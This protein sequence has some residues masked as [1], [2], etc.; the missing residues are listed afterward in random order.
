MPRT[1]T[2]E[3]ETTETPEVQ[4]AL[5]GV[6]EDATPETVDV[7]VLAIDLPT[8]ARADRSLVQ[9][10]LRVGLLN[11][12][13][14]I[15]RGNRF[16]VLA[17]RRRVNAVKAIVSD[18]ALTDDQRVRFAK[19]EARV[20]ER[21]D[22]NT[23]ERAS[24]L[25]TENGNRSENPLA[26][27]AAIKTIQTRTGADAAA[28]ARDLNQSAGWVRARLDLDS[29]VPELADAMARGRMTFTTARK[30]AKLDAARQRRLVRIIED[31]ETARITEDDVRELRQVGPAHVDRLFTQPETSA[32]D[33]D[34]RDR[35]GRGDANILI[36]NE[37]A[38]DANADEAAA[39]MME[40]NGSPEHNEPAGTGVTEWAA[41]F[42]QIASNTRVTLD[43]LVTN[44]TT[45]PPPVRGE[46]RKAIR[47]IEKAIT[48]HAERTENEVN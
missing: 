8:A 7:D 16:E 38:I 24:I 9:S 22:V 46:L 36:E 29:L 20:Y 6:N 5:I 42:A 30:V 31:S 40:L 28:I 17:G 47:A 12:P 4:P 37:R 3:T 41:N 18:R 27:L 13:T 35:E 1:E 25:L 15:K 34:T 48:L 19:I 33:H 23:A 2:T 26:E 44:Y 11:P 21:D 43:M 32:P 10:I 39:H 14:L 45:M